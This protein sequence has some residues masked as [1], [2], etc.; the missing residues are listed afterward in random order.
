MLAADAVEFIERHGLGPVVVLGHSM[1]GK[2]GMRLALEH[3]EV[4]SQLVVVDISPTKQSQG[5]RPVLEAMLAIEP[6]N[7]ASREEVDRALGEKISD[8]RLRQFLLTN[9]ER[10]DAG[11]FRWRLNLPAIDTHFEELA[12]AIDADESYLGPTLFVRGGRSDYVRD[13]D[14]D[15][16]RRLFPS[17]EVATVPGAGHWVHAEAPA[18]LVRVVT[19]FLS[20]TSASG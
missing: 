20:R 11:A 9:V 10:G 12:V 3:S 1:G 17:A 18:A 5:L 16:I 7:Y 4:V 2:V 6:G 19:D 13:S 15:T 14:I 8:Q